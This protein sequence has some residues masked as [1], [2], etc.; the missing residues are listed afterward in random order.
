M[1]SG[2]VMMQTDG[3]IVISPAGFTSLQASPSAVGFTANK[4]A[5]T[6]CHGS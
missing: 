1:T 2:V 6:F 4:M 3:V 5:I